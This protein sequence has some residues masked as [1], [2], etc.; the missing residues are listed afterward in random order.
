MPIKK[1][2]GS[3]RDI[4]AEYRRLKDAGRHVEA[5]ELL[6][7]AVPA[8]ATSDGQRQ[9]PAVER[10]GF[11]EE[12][13]PE[14]DIP[15]SGKV[16]FTEQDFLPKVDVAAAAH[17]PATAADTSGLT[18]DPVECQHC[19]HLLSRPAVEVSKDDIFRYEISIAAD[20]P[21][22]KSYSSLRGKLQF[23]FRDLSL[24]EQDLCSRQ[25]RID[26]D[27]GRAADGMAAL[28][29]L[30]RYEIA[31]AL[32]RI[33]TGDREIELPGDASEWAAE[34]AEGETIL[35]E[36]LT[37]LRERV[38]SSASTLRIVSTA[39]GRFRQLIRRLEDN[40]DNDPFWQATESGV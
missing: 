12:P 29:L 11:R 5:D 6:K 31:L 36:V 33:K 13:T 7:N 37:E 4:E 25:A 9:E 30:H 28:E 38:I 21:F 8:Q 34:A 20:Q 18:H 32:R 39:Y 27:K 22:E 23:T 16:T 17:E 26:L 10:V 2:K 40:S 1:T 24:A 19:G 3:V 14:V 35:P 15:P